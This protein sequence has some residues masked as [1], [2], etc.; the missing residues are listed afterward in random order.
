MDNESSK[1]R[2]S[3]YGE[4]SDSTFQDLR[5]R[6]PIVAHIMRAGG[7]AKDCAV[8]LATDND[9]LIARLIALESIVP[10]RIK[11]PDGRVKVWHC[12]DSMVPEV[13]MGGQP[14]ADRQ[15]V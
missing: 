1:E 2:P 11:L 5:W 15:G 4:V 14:P 9:R 13:D 7:T 8:A 6:N 12:P 3:K 10:R